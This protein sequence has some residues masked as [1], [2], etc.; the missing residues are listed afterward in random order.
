MQETIQEIVEFE[1]VG[2]IFLDGGE[3]ILVGTKAY[4]A[5]KDVKVADYRIKNSSLIK[6]LHAFTTKQEKM[7]VLKEEDL[8]DEEQKAY[9]K[10]AD[11]IMDVVIAHKHTLEFAGQKIK[12]KHVPAFASAVVESFK[13]KNPD[14]P[15]SDRDFIVIKVSFEKKN[16]SIES[17]K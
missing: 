3:M 17:I 2:R 14:T 7:E 5:I 1:D 8:N 12:V 10:I 11:E 15:V 6:E 16:I 4:E 13:K 9:E